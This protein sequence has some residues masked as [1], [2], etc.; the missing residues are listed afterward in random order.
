MALNV[1]FVNIDLQTKQM[2]F[3]LPSFLK[4]TTNFLNKLT[5]KMMLLIFLILSGI[6]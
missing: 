4:D 5:T 3:Q 2:A 6:F 1:P